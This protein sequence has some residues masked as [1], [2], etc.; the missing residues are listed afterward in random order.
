MAGKTDKKDDKKKTGDNTKKPIPEKA[1]KTQE[2]K[3]EPVEKPEEK[4]KTALKLANDF[5]S[6]HKIILG[7]LVTIGT[8]VISALFY[9]YRQGYL[10]YFNVSNEWNNY[11]DKSLFY[12]LALPFCLLSLIIVM[13]SLLF[14]IVKKMGAWLRKKIPKLEKVC[15]KILSWG[16]SIGVIVSILAALLSLI[17][18]VIPEKSMSPMMKWAEQHYFAFKCFCIILGVVLILSLGYLSLSFGS[19]KMPAFIRFFVTITAGAGFMCYCIG[20]VQA[21]D[22]NVFRI[23]YMDF[24]D[25]EALTETGNED[26]PVLKNVISGLPQPSDGAI[27]QINEMLI[28]TTNPIQ[29]SAATVTTTTLQTT[30]NANT[31]QPESVIVYVVLAENKDFY[32]A[33]IGEIEAG[34]ILNIDRSVQYTFEKKNQIILKKRFQDVKFDYTYPKEVTP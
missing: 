21:K 2:S 8:I 15:N 4:T 30:T 19:Q 28:T 22:Q 24:S 33:E 32:L 6:D 31:S 18:L 20:F 10:S 5:I 27:Y 7:L 34:G 16:D 26:S 1:N 14:M 29:S 11:A 9:I 12:K 23:V 3:Q 17:E 25:N 13:A